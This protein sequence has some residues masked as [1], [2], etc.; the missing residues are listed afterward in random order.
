MAP[1]YSGRIP[2]SFIESVT[3]KTDIVALIQESI[4]LKKMGANYSACCPFHHEKTPSFTVSAHKQ[5]YH[6][7][8][9][10]AHGNAISFMMEYQAL[11]FVEAVEKLAARLGLTV[12]RDPHEV[13]KAQIKSSTTS[14][15]NS[16]AE[17]YAFALKNHPAAKTA[18]NYLKKRGLTG[19][20]AKTYC[21]GYAP[22]GWDNL[23]SHFQHD[24][25]K[26]KVLEETGLIIKHPEGRLYDR[27]R[28]RVMFPIRD[29]RGDV[30][31]FGGRVMDISQPKYLNS[32]ESP[33]FQKGHCLYGVYEANKSKEKWQT[34]IIVEGYMDVV[35]LAQFGIV[36]ALATLGTAITS[37][38]LTS[39]FSLSSEVVFCF[40]GD[41]AGQAAAW[42]ALQLV[43]PSLTEGRQVRF[44][45]LPQG[46][47][48]DTYVRNA[49]AADFMQLIK[50]GMPLSEYFFS[51]L[52]Q[53]I[54]PD[55]VD[56]RAHLASLAR[57]YLETL[58]Q[59]IFKE[60]MFEQLAQLVSSSSYVVRGERAPRGT[61]KRPWQPWPK[62]PEMIL[63]PRPK[64]L[65][66]AFIASG[67]LLRLPTLLSVVQDCKPFWEELNTPGIDLLKKIL[68][69]LKATPTLSTDDL[70]ELLIQDG[71][72]ANRLTEC[73][74]KA[75]MIPFEG[76]EAEFRGTISCLEVIGRE[77]FTEKLLQKSK[78]GDLTPA[79]K[80]QLKDFLNFR[81]SK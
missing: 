58:P 47:D 78:K 31:G 4:K 14:V 36:G 70:R 34:A 68:N 33:I 32:P 41:K 38:H 19:S 40:D 80:Q 66:L 56:N 51:T 3:A 59:G 1:A 15:L 5:F 16:V 30:I 77:H 7:F 25:E 57:P 17:F 72:L 79:E 49:G 35:A 63:T 22:P 62:K 43:L 18:V 37:H 27:F 39:L 60:M 20:I 48:P 13:Q 52:S 10:G 74:S 67:I 2:D 75:A 44:T 64:P 71:I 73:E 53:K 8:G 29:R 45:F 54:K 24:T 12:P 76:L 46:E 42:K 9:C 55:S 11:S 26:L 50:N 81:E 61:Y 69:L 21:I 65:A 6:C 28:D 23:L